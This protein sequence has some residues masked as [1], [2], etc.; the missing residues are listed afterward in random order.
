M[1]RIIL[2]SEFFWKFNFPSI[3]RNEWILIEYTNNS[4]MNFAIALLAKMVSVALR[5]KITVLITPD[6]K[7]LPFHS[8]LVYKILGVNSFEYLYNYISSEGRTILYKFREDKRRIQNIDDIYQYEFNSILIGD[9]LYDMVLRSNKWK[10]TINEANDDLDD[11]LYAV[12]ATLIYVDSILQSKKVVSSVFSH[13]TMLGGVIQRYLL[14]K[15]NINGVIGSIHTSIRKIKYIEEQRNPYPAYL[16]LNMYNKIITNH[17]VKEK[18]LDLANKF[19]GLKING[20]IK[21]FDNEIAFSKDSYLF[22]SKQEFNSKYNLDQNKKNVF[23]ALHVFNDQP[24]TLNGIYRDYYLWFIDSVDILSQNQN[25]NLIIKEHPSTK[26]YPTSDF[27]LNYYLKSNFLENTNFLLINSSE[28]FNSASIK[29]IADLVITSGGSIALEAL[30]WGVPSITC[31]SSYYSHFNLI[32]RAKSIE[33]YHYL[34]NNCQKLI[35]IEVNIIEDA[36]II[37]YLTHGVLWDGTWNNNI[38]LPEM[39][40]EDKTNPKMEN[41]FAYYIKFLFSKESKKYIKN[42][43]DFIRNDKREVFFRDSELVELEKN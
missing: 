12:I 34:L 13:P 7:K 38:F 22:N 2:K 14:L 8:S 10:A 11:P 31:S 19:I 3:K 41:I 39:S 5:A 4:F 27:D 23:L 15:H 30:C 35:E 40:F 20:N 16:S 29:Y 26:F 1:F 36:K 21:H 9:L 43:I 28:S 24:N 25:I 17:I 6:I 32:K 42:M 18:Y 37:Y 33:D